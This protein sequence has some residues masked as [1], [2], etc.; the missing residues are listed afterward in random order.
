MF[1]ENMNNMIF[2]LLSSV[3][4]CII[5]NYGCAD[6]LC[7]HKNKLHVANK[8]FENTTYNDISGIGIPELLM[9][10]ISC[11]GFVNNTKSDAILSYRSKLVDYCL[12][13][14]FVIFENNSSALRNVPLH[15]KQKNNAGHIYK[16]I[17]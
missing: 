12:S 1:Y 3:V 16:I 8:G 17:S 5:N 9:N 11:R 13:K 6:Y 2:K 7:C 10:I 4:Y 14:G 15:A